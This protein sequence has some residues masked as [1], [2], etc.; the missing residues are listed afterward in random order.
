MSQDGQGSCLLYPTD[1]VHYSYQMSDD[2][3]ISSPDPSDVTQAAVEAMPESL[4]KPLEV[5]SEG[6]D[7]SAVAQQSEPPS[8]EAEKGMRLQDLPLISGSE[9]SI[10]RF[11]EQSFTNPASTRAASQ[12]L[13]ETF[14]DK[15]LWLATLIQPMHLAEELSQQCSILSPLV[16]MQWVRQGETQKLKTLSEILLAEPAAGRT[17]ESACIMTVLAGVLGILRPSTAQKL[18]NSATPY[19]SDLEDGGLLRDARQWVE[20]GRILEGSAP[21]ERVFWNR[22]LRE[23]GNDW[24]WNSAEARLALRHLAGKLPREGEILQVF[25]GA[26]PGCWWDLWRASPA[27]VGSVHLALLAPPSSDSRKGRFVLGLLLGMAAAL[28]LGGVALSFMPELLA[29]PS[30]Q[31]KALAKSA[32]ESDSDEADSAP[33]PPIRESLRQLQ[34][35]LHK[36]FPATASTRSGPPTTSAVTTK[37]PKSASA[38]LISG[39]SK[40]AIRASTLSQYATEHEDARRLVS[41][42]KNSSYRENATLIQGGNSVAPKGSPAYQGMIQWLILDP[43]ELADV[44]LAVT[45][46]ALHSLPVDDTIRLFDLCF[47]PGSPNEIEIK[48]CASLLLELPNTSIT[49]AHRGVLNQ[50]VSAP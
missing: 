23:P 19:L 40:Q 41:L 33:A 50:I 44:R 22:H 7:G 16:L 25:Q 17:H 10:E 18:I 37:G 38:P 30:T 45:K 8:T 34:S 4:T 13:V 39:Q 20:A 47:Y 48:Q 43:P 6:V 28:A 1:A 27:A 49:G 35:V 2:P 9:P 46:L 24:D 3:T 12:S 32:Q 21:E 14:N 15:G 5:H 26:V 11:I 42:V 29:P 31:A 36:T